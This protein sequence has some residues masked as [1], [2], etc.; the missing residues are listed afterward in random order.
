MVYTIPIHI[1]ALQ[2]LIRCQTSSINDTCYFTKCQLTKRNQINE[3]EEVCVRYSLKT[4]IKQLSF[5]HRI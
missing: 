1:N 3:E 2:I 4:D 5:I